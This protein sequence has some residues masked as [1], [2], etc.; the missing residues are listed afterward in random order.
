MDID[1]GEDDVVGGVE[2]SE[3]GLGA[4]A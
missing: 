4:E 2:V 1:E 3:M